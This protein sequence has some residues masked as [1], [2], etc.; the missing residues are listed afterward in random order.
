MSTNNNPI[1][2]KKKI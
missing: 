1:K 2:K